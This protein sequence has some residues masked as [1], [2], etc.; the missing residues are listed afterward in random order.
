M[1]WKEQMDGNLDSSRSLYEYLLE[2][3]VDP[4]GLLAF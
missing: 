2:G 1:F 3:C 4:H